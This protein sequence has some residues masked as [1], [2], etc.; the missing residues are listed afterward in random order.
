MA[1]TLVETPLTTR[2]ARRRLACRR[3]PYWNRLGPREKLGY[4]KNIGV[5]SWLASTYDPTK[6]EGSKYR[7][8]MLGPTDD[9]P[10]PG[11]LSYDQAVAKALSYFAEVRRAAEIEAAGPA[12]TIAMS[13]QGYVEDRDAR[14]SRRKGRSV[15]SDASRRLHRYILGQAKRGKS[16]AI[17]PAPIA[18]KTLQELEEEDLLAWRESLPK[19]MRATSKQRL[20]NDFK[21]AL[22][23]TYA[24]NRKSLPPTLSS[25]IKFGLRAI[26]SNDEDEDHSIARKNQILDDGD[27][28]RLIQA[29]REIDREQ[30]WEGDLFR[31]IVVLAATG[32]RFSQ[33]I[34]IRVQDVQ[35]ASDRLM[36][37]KSRKGKFAKSGHIAIP[38]GRDVMDQLASATAGKPADEI[39]LHRWRKVQR[40][41][42][43]DWHRGTR[44]PW[45]SSSE[46]DRAWDLIVKRVG[47]PEA[48]PYCFR[49]SSIVRMLRQ[50]VNVR[51]V[52]ALHDTSVAMI[53]KH[54]AAYIVDALEDIVRAAIVPLM[55]A[56]AIRKGL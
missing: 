15:R 1:R 45:Q 30:G 9:D 17:S 11:T 13:V 49:H 42:S 2:T 21:A 16:P 33:V 32:A 46:I 38:V 10:G 34:R 14:E 26:R 44:G 24:A 36:V 54:Y 52:A 20:I 6:S 51:L 3:K 12:I 55:P 47:L 50:N 41:G 18:A 19:E 22:N 31:I 29:A 8:V 28:A 56:R 39:L 35:I 7:E 25:A 4:R 37:P 53:E 40:K 27:I 5:S 43:L 23:T 48:V